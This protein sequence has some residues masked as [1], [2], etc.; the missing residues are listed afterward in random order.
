MMKSCQRITIGDFIEFSSADNLPEK[1][2]TRVTALH[3]F[4]GFE[5]LYSALSKEKLGYSHSDTADAHDMEEYY[6]LDKPER[7][8]GG[9]HRASHDR[10][11]EIY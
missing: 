1:I 9:R 3:R 6:S 5:E 7:V 2:Q 4:S 10:S 11:S 8:R